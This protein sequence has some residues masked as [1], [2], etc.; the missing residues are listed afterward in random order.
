[1]VDGVVLVI[2]MVVGAGTLE[3]VV[4]SLEAK[5]AEV[6]FLIEGFL[7]VQVVGE[8]A[9]IARNGEGPEDGRKYSI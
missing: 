4:G 8:G 3:A 5:V 2:E 9:T 1:M 6:D 7:M